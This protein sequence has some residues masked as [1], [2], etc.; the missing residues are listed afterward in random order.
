MDK[1]CKINNG[2]AQGSLTRTTQW[3][4]NVALVFIIIIGLK[5]SAPMITQMLIILFIAIVISPIYYLLRRLRLPS[6]LALTLM[7]AAMALLFLY[8]INIVLTRSLLDFSKK[9]P[10]YHHEIGLAMNDFSDWLKNQGVEVPEA[11]FAD[12][13][14]MNASTVTGLVRGIG[15]KIGNF[16]K[17]S[18]L[19]LIIV[20]FI[21]CELPSLPKK[22]KALP[23]M[24]DAT[25]ER[26]YKIVNDVR[27]YMSIKTAISAATGIG[28]YIGLSIMGIDSAVL[29][30]ILAFVLNFVPVIGSI[31]AAVPAVLIALVQHDP[32]TGVYVALLYTAVNMALGNILEPR[33]M[34]YGF[35]VSPVVV[36]FSLIF[37]GWVLGPLGML[38][39]V[40]LTMALRGSIESILRETMHDD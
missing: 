39:A 26:L 16:L 31:I 6:W 8:G 2:M 11:V 33:L 3:L 36:L 24:T 38:F 10:E 37:W 14:S 21:L 35:G 13:K 1:D 34:G 23:W 27:H 12:A 20:S 32:L 18:I 9:V 29:L 28:I 19:A 7:I 5:F 22:V 40:P 25:W 4:L 17:D 15:T 30:A